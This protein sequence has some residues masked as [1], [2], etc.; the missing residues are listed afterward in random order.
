[1][2]NNNFEQD[3]KIVKDILTPK[4]TPEC[5][6]TFSPGKQKTAT[7]RVLYMR[8]ASVAA[9]LAVA[10]IFF[11]QINVVEKSYATGITTEMIER[12]IEKISNKNTLY[13]EVKSYHMETGQATDGKIYFLKKDSTTYMREEWNDRQSTV[14]IYDKDSLQLWQNGAF[15]GKSAIPFH[16]VNCESFFNMMSNVLTKIGDTSYVLND[17]EESPT[18]EPCRTKEGLPLYNIP[19]DRIESITVS[20]EEQT[21]TFETKPAAKHHPFCVLLFSAE[22]EAFTNIKIVMEDADTS[23]KRVLAEITTIAYDYPITLNDIM[24]KPE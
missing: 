22:K 11:T 15:K 24:R 2:N 19:A 14:A 5:K 8:I 3:N 1:M 21:I 9:V 10:L 12:A 4:H 7:R 13:L 17:L 18:H 6:I 23:Q 20:K 16:P